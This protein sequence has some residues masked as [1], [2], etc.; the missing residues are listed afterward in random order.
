LALLALGLRRRLGQ[1]ANATH[2]AQV[3]A[4]VVANLQVLAVSGRRHIV[5]YDM[6][7][8]LL[9][10]MRFERSAE[11]RGGVRIRFCHDLEPWP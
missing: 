11:H 2:R 4:E 8:E 6:H 10:E 7:P 3:V 1:R 9:A 5:A